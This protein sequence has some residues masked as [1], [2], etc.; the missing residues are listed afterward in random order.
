MQDIEIEIDAGS[1]LGLALS[2]PPFLPLLPP[3]ISRRLAI[4]GSYF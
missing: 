1:A 3:S 2:L 4:L